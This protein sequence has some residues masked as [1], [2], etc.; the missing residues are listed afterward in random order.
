MGVTVGVFSTGVT[1]DVFGGCCS[2]SVLLTAA[3]DAGF[4][5]FEACF[6]ACFVVSR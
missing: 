6:A 4:E 5:A 1:A 2:G 3:V